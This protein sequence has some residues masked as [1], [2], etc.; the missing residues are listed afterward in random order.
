M[1]GKRTHKVFFNDLFITFKP[2]KYNHLSSE[3]LGSFCRPTAHKTKS[4]CSCIFLK[5]ES[6]AV[7][8]DC[9]V[10][11]RTPK[12]FFAFSGTMYPCGH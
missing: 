8:E 11:Y 5:G 4:N 3:F 10:E 2:L 1:W 6:T 12:L 9:L 7:N